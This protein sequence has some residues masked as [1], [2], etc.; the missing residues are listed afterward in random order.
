MLTIEQ[1]SE[2]LSTHLQTI[3]RDAAARQSELAS[4]QDEFA[5][6]QQ[7]N[8][9]RQKESLAFTR[10]LEEKIANTIG[11]VSVLLQGVEPA[12]R[13]ANAIVTGRVGTR[14]M[15]ISGLIAVV[16][17]LML[18]HF[19][20]YAL[21]FSCLAGKSTAFEIWTSY[22]D[23]H[24]VLGWTIPAVAHEA[25]QLTQHEPLRRLHSR[26]LFWAILGATAFATPFLYFLRTH[27]R[28]RQTHPLVDEKPARSMRMASDSPKR[29][30]REEQRQRTFRRAQTVE[31]D[32]I[33]FY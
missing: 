7:A 24:Q 21:I 12:M 6:M 18:L 13:A 10:Q 8:I 29:T 19:F 28:S 4:G 25:P 30:R 11:E 17:L 23:N 22:A 32:M 9:Q 14:F 31:P 2:I 27:V 33:G 15:L 26:H 5:T 20:R 1:Q 16:M 3:M